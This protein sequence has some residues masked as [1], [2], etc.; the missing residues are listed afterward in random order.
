MKTTSCAMDSWPLDDLTPEQQARLVEVLEG[1]MKDLD[2]GREPD[3]DRAAAEHPELAEPLAVCLD[4]V[5]FLHRAALGFECAEANEEPPRHTVQRQI[6]DYRIVR[7]IGRGGMGVVY[8]AQQTSLNRRVAL[9]VLPFAAVLDQRQIARFE[10]EARAAAQLHHPHIVPVFAVGCERGVHYYAMQYVEGQPFDT[11]IEEMGRP[12]AATR[13]IGEKDHTSSGESKA[14]SDNSTL[15]SLANT[16]SAGS[17]AYFRA[18]CQLGIQ[19]ADALQHAHDY[20]IVHRDVKPSNLL[21]DREAKLWI[22]DFGLARCQADTGMTTTGQVIGTLNYMS[23]EQAAGKAGL[24]DHRTDIYSLG[25]TLYEALTLCPAFEGTDRS[26]LLKRIGEEEPK[27]PR[28][29]NPAIPVDLE[30]IVL[31]AISKLPS[32]RYA[33]AGEMAEDLQRFLDGKPTL[34]RRPTLAQRAGKW[35][36]RHRRAV[37]SAVVLVAVAIAG[38]L[39]S[40][41]LIS[42]AQSRTSA[43]LEQAET[44]LE[45]AETHYREAREVVDLFGARLAQ[46]LAEVPGAD[47]LRYELLNRTLDYYRGFVDHAGDDPSLQADLAFTHFKTA[48]IAEQMGDSERAAAAYTDARRVFAQLASDQPEDPAYRGDLALCHNNLG[49]LA[50]RAGDTVAAAAAYGRAIEIQE[51]LTLKFP[52]QSRFQAELA[53]SYGNLG[54]LAQQT[55]RVTEAERAYRQAIAIE[56]DLAAKYSNRPKYQSDLAIS[57]SNL[58]SLHAKTEPSAAVDYCRRAI[59][60]FAELADRHP[61]V[62][63]YQSD[64][65]LACNNLGTLENHCGQM[66]ESAASF[67]RAV[68]LQR[69]LT[70]KA[71]AQISYRR[72]LAVTYNNLGRLQGE[73]DETVAAEESLANARGIFEDLVSDYPNELS[74]RSSLGGVL[75]NQAMALER[76]NRP[77]EAERAYREAV[78]H[79]R[80]ALERASEVVRYREFLSK[81]YWNYGQFLLK[82]G[83]VREAGSVALTRKTLW[84]DNPDRLYGVA[85]ELAAIVG[86]SEESDR[87]ETPGEGAED[88]SLADWAV[89]TLQEAVAKGLDRPDR[90]REDPDLSEIR[91][92]P[93]FRELLD[94]LADR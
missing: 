75:N 39:T 72:D 60:I 6:G 87:D 43:A 76:L 37:F 68:E 64:L 2:Q 21:L 28:R 89:T 90:L 16:D 57:Y 23:P 56:E 3:M 17:R 33:S 4:S 84:E 61:H 26:E 40:T 94:M 92:H 70:R 32:Q 82:Q 67:A 19:A 10:N 79:Q 30:T 14:S 7:E 24:M 9:K 66:G 35:A 45:R 48:A 25:I 49:L 81:H 74:Y 63:R 18:I 93:R 34:A 53:L 31:K 22:T 44:N 1:Y 86:R 20:G 91:D 46:Q 59:E 50:G 78:E 47:Q 13:A 15:R 77:E 73:A 83:R 85:V 71:P 27:L 12:G 41:L 5:N 58:S 42:R 69:Q 55:D 80:I 29:I 65:A 54:L 52:E 62:L 11:A 38:L 51:E 36:G 8:E 88:E